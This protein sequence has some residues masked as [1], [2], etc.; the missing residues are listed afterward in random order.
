MITS[1]GGVLAAALRQVYD[2]EDGPDNAIINT[3]VFHPAWKCEVS[4]GNAF[5]WNSIFPFKLA[6][7]HPSQLMVYISTDYVFDGEKTGPYTE[8][9]PPCPINTYGISKYA[10]ELMVAQSGVEYLIIRTST[11][12]GPGTKGFV[13]QV[14]DRGAA[15]IPL[16]V[17]RGVVSPT[18]VPDLA[19]EIK[20]L[21]DIQARGVYH[22]TSGSSVTLEDLAKT[23]L[24]MAGFKTKIELVDALPGDTV[25]RPR[26]ASLRSV[27]LEQPMR[28]WREGL[29]EYLIMGVQK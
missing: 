27:R 20:R 28:D 6:Q 4:P 1:R 17:M 26:N 23:V 11:F 3:K 12:F 22:I 10:G 9:D 24:T 13:R 5:Y 14:L 16:L 8:D 2:S 29:K 18:Y 19:Q 25:R 21:I 15:Q 7:K